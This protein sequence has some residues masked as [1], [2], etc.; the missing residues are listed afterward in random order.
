M[1]GTDTDYVDIYVRWM[2]IGEMH[3]D[4]CSAGIVS[5][6]THIDYLAC[7]SY[8]YVIVIVCCECGLEIAEARS[9][10]ISAVNKNDRILSTTQRQRGR[11]RDDDDD[12]GQNI[13]VDGSLAP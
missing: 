11:R 3:T 5:C 7:D 9:A 10:D 8:S 12:D 1:D 13:S 2:S 4:Y 6:T